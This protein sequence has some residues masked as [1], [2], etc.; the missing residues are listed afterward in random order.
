M[1][2]HRILAGVTIL[3][4]AAGVIA[5]WLRPKLASLAPV[6]AQSPPP[7]DRGITNN[8]QR[9][10]T[11]G[12]QIFRFDT[13]GDEVYWSDALHLQLA[14]E[15]TKFGG[16]G[17]GLTPR[18]AL[19]VGLKV[20]VDA[21]PPDLQAALQAGQVNL[22]DA[23][24]T[25][26]LLRLNAVVGV[27]GQFAGQQLTAVGVTCAACH[28]TVDNSFAPGIGHRVDGWGN[29]DLNVGAIVAL[30]P[31]LLP[32]ADLLGVDVATVRKV[33][34][35]WGPGKFDAILDKDGKAFR[36]DGKPA[37]TILPNAWG[38]AGVN[39]HTWGGGWGNVTYWNAFVANT[40]LNG[41]GTFFDR[42]L[43]DPIKYPVS[44][45]SGSWN[46]RIKPD[47]ITRKLAALHFY[48]L[49]IP[50]PEP[51]AGSFDPDAAARG[52][53]LF[54]GKAQC[55][56]CHVPPLYTEPGWN[57]HRGEEIGIDNF[58]GNRTPDNSYRTAP[59]KGLWTRTLTPDAKPTTN[60]GFY[61]DG[62]FATLRD[63]IVH[64]NQF[65]NL[66]LIDQEINDLVEFLKSL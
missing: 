28:S 58:Q 61:H 21:L 36:P 42:R 31:N 23:A 6:G 46:K 40:E 62:R 35:S 8:V 50:S 22:D 48:Q 11:E 63:V 15:G 29:R 59:L 56:T 66:G 60:P 12:R 52:E 18:Q 45:K 57:T 51:P 33:L 17:S 49:S 27:I 38:L 4:L 53:A 2:R 3:A 43:S 64:Y 13:F 26:A 32:I 5:V 9:L 65:F 55:A 44:A 19:Q 1:T 37:A 10:F 34:M 47:R 30:A 54:E 24:T 39:L 20:D 25:V 7:F 14:I 16:V 41:T